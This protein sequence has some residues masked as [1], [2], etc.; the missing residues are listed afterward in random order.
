MCVCVC[1]YLGNRYIK[2]CKNIKITVQHYRVS[3]IVLMN[4]VQILRGT[5]TFNYITGNTQ[6]SNLVISMRP[7]FANATHSNTIAFYSSWELHRN[8]VLIKN[9]F[10]APK[11]GGPIC[12]YKHLYSVTHNARTHTHTHIQKARDAKEILLLVS[13]I[14]K[15]ELEVTQCVSKLMGFVMQCFWQSGLS[16][17]QVHFRDTNW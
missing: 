15:L 13:E 1:A 5:N 16:V 6:M 17:N 7:Q 2:R 3:H 9:H 14:P 10:V 4:S 8:C 11:L 12:V